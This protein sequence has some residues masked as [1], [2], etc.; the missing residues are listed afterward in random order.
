MPK[1]PGRFIWYELLT[2]DPKAAAKFYGD[3]IGWTVNAVGGPNGDYYQW[4]MAGEGVGGMMTIPAPASAD[5]MQP[6]WLGYI[7][8]PDVD[9]AAAAITAAGGAIHMPP[10]DIPGIG[11]TA[12]VADPQG[13][14]F[15]V[16]APIG[17]GESRVFSP[18][19]LGHGGWNE[20]HSSDGAAGCAFYEAQ[21][22]WRKSSAFDM[23]PMG[24]YQLFN[25]GAED[26]GGMMTNTHVP[27]PLWLFYFNVEDIN[28][29]KARVEAAGGAVTNGPHQV[30]TGQ[31]MLQA[32]DPQGATFALLAPQ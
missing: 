18:G 31:W 24:T 11:R 9:Q 16:M 13:A 19:V 20:L 2:T 14:S 7:N 26:L 6:G 29:A 12:L 17:E 32:T 8:T 4:A 30:P 25:A 28:A 5:E 27:R 1:T 10:F 3:V 23:G 22:G 21:F 15:Y